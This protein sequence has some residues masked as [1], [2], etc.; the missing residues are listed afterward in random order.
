[1]NSDIVPQSS[2]IVN[3]LTPQQ[4]RVWQRLTSAPPEAR[5]ADG[6]VRADYLA[7]AWPGG[8]TL[9]GW[10]NLLRV[11][12]Y[13]LNHNLATQHVRVVGRVGGSGPNA[14]GY[15][16]VTTRERAQ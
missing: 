2:M 6:R 13:S 11:T 1:M 10:R 14:G 16:V 12:I 9:P 7:E 8:A 15:A 4:A 3:S 5:N